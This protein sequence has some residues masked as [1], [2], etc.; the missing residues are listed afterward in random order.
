MCSRNRIL[1]QFSGLRGEYGSDGIT[2]GFDSLYKK[3]ILNGRFMY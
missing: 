1:H 3:V 2:L